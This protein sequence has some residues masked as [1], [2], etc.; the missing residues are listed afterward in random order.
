MV[1]KFWKKYVEA[2]ILERAKIIEKLVQFPLW[3]E[4][5][6]MV[7]D[8]KIPEHIRIHAM[9]TILQG[10]FDDLIDYMNCKK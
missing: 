10:Y 7:N 4:T 2:D 8:E 3:K 9:A 5:F 6:T 1:E